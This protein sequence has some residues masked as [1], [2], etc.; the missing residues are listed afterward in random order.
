MYD[1]KIQ[2][3]GWA[4]SEWN[5]AN[6]EAAV[7]KYQSRIYRFIYSILRQTHLA[8]DLT[9]DTFLL[10]YKA[11]CKKAEASCTAIKDENIPDQGEPAPPISAWL[12]T[13]ARNV[14]ISELRRQKLLQVSSFWYSD[15]AG[16]EFELIN[17]AFVERESVLEGQFAIHD[18]LERALKDVGQDRVA[19]LL[20]FM[21][22]FSY[23]EI[24]DLTGYNL[25][26]VR[27]QIYRAKQSLRHYLLI[28]FADTAA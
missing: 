14:A 19:A 12:Y 3:R 26:S 20:L 2:A 13:I 6:F 7:I 28:Q 15:T 24:C 22:G 23:L 5:P 16:N 17:P 18:E 8:Q 27:S 4:R 11:L 9:Q 21:D 10:A 25:S 1:Y